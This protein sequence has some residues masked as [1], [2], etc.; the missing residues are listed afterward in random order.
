MNGISNKALAFG[1]PANKM[2]YNGK[3]EQKEEFSD[4]S[5]LEW[6]DFGA[7]MYDAQ[8]GRWMAH[9]PLAEKYQNASPYSSF[10]NNPIVFFDPDG[11]EI[12]ISYIEDGKTKTYTYTY[13]KDRKLDDKLPDFVKKSVT[14]LD[15]LYSS[16]AMVRNLTK[17]VESPIQIKINMLQEMI[18]DKSNTLTIIEETQSG[19]KNEYD[20]ETNTIKFN[21][22]EGF[23]FRKD[24][25]LFSPAGSSNWKKNSP[26][27]RLGHELLHGYNDFYDSEYTTRRAD[28]ST[29]NAPGMRT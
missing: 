7:R 26:T 10:G 27:S 17:D 12:V 16:G 18:D 23:M 29:R 1:T 24:P 13:E 2:K 28:I 11:K 6:T 19:K 5:G 22:N 3:E 9:D 4:G 14:A 15:K 8:I 20:P 25:T 21:P